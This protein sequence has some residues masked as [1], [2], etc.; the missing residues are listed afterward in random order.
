MAFK[1]ESGDWTRYR[2]LPSCME[3]DFHWSNDGPREVPYWEAMEQVWRVALESLQKAQKNGSQY[4]IFTHDS[5]TSSPVQPTAR[6]QIRK[7]MRSPAATP[8]I[9]RKKCIQ[10]DSVFVAAIKQKSD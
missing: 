8:Y 3:V 10:H 4:V 9:I 5:S 7:L 6:S 2:Q 1:T